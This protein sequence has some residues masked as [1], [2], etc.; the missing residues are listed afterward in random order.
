MGSELAAQLEPLLHLGIGM[1]LRHVVQARIGE[2][3]VVSILGSPAGPT[4]KADPSPSI[5]F[6]SARE[7]PAHDRSGPKID[8]SLNRSKPF[9]PIR[10][11]SPVTG[12]NAP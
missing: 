11:S 6:C 8:G 12:R 5:A 4:A 9:V 3:A 10:M 1:H 7:S 2:Q